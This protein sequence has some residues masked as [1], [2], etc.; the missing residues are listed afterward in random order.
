MNKRK[1]GS[2]R[3]LKRRRIEKEQKIVTG[4][5]RKSEKRLKTLPKNLE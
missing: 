4:W 2:E 3:E 1:Y 5:K